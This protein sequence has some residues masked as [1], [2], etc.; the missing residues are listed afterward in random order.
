MSR[1]LASNWS[2]VDEDLRTQVKPDES[3][4]EYKTGEHQ[5]EHE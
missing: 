3:P 4:D 2:S 5:H 1:N